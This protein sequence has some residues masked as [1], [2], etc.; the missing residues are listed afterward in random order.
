MALNVA[1]IAKKKMNMFLSTFI[2]PSQINIWI[3]DQDTFTSDTNVKWSPDKTEQN[4]VFM[5]KTRTN[6]SMEYENLFSLFVFV[7]I[8]SLLHFDQFK[9]KRVVI[10]SFSSKCI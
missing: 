8:I 10:L 6:M 1:S 3:L 9:W 5:L 7:L 4:E 2:F